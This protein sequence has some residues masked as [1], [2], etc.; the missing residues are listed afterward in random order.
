[1][2]REFCD[3]T[4]TSALGTW[5]SLGFDASR[6]RFHER[7]DLA[8]RPLDVPHRAMVQARQ[9]Y[10]FAHAALLDRSQAER[11]LLAERAMQGLLRDFM[12]TSGDATSFRFS[13]TADGAAASDLRDS[14]THAFVLF[15]LGWMYRL[16]GDPQLLGVADRTAHFVDQ[17]LTDP[18]HGG[19][20]DATPLPDG[21][22][23]RQNPLMHL[24]EA[25]ICLES[26]APGR[27]FLERCKHLV[28]LVRD[29]FVLP[30]P[31]VLL[32]HRDRDWQP[33]PDLEKA[34]AWE[35]GHHLE[36]VWLLGEY[37]RLAGQEA[38]F[39]ECLWNSALRSGLAESGL[40][41][42]EVRVDL[43]VSKGS[44]RVWPHTEG[45]KAGAA[46]HASGDPAGRAFAERM[47]AG[48]MTTFLDRPFPGA[49]IDHVSADRQP[50]VDYVPASSLYHIFLATAVA[51]ETWPELRPG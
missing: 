46:R 5:A 9:I 3:W 23:K 42:D 47:A 17:S 27:G 31:G 15:A 28:E 2:L 6:G 10:V 24:L 33:H 51:C 4:L 32:E 34:G 43:T 41:V 16:N 49:W 20:Y 13:V 40:L 39:S 7:L 29:R 38:N 12:I 11:G 1:M 25:Y 19:L 26:V 35:P 18:A 21:S 44:H 50:L 30:Q 8:G 36:W 45:I 14:Y 48:L 37:G 22:F